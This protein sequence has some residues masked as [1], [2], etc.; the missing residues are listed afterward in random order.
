MKIAGKGKTVNWIISSSAIKRI[1]KDGPWN[2]SPDFGRIV[3]KTV[4]F[5]LTPGEYEEMLE[6]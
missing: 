6:V 3:M 1:Y 5:L 2:L 4:M